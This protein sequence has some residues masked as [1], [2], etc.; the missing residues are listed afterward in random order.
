MF[1]HTNIKQAD[2]GWI[3]YRKKSFS[4][5]KGNLSVNFVIK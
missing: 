1:S 3:E 5:N 4:N 2:L